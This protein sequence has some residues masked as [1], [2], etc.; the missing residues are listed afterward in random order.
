MNEIPQKF[1]EFVKNVSW[2]YA[3]TYAKKAPHEYVVKTYLDEE[4]QKLFEELAI[5]IRENGYTKYFFSKAFIYLDIGNYSFWTYGD[6]I[7]DT[8]ILNRAEI[9]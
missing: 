3:K 6:P 4:E 1:I 9:L 8:I 2:R 5:Y 7:P